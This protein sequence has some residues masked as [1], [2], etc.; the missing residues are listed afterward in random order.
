MNVLKEVKENCS[1]D[2]NELEGKL[3][4][5]ICGNKSFSTEL[6]IAHSLPLG[7][8]FWECVPDSDFL[9]VLRIH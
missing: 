8:S 3:S 5:E 9:F 4:T 7:I 6:F 2:V 1:E